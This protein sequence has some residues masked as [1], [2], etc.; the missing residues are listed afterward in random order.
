MAGRDFADELEE[1]GPE[2][3]RAAGEAAEPIAA[4]AED[5]AEPTPKR[6]RKSRTKRDLLLTALGP[7]LELWHDDEDRPYASVV[8]DGHREHWAMDSDR[9][10]LAVTSTYYKAHSSTLSAQALNDALRFLRAEAVCNGPQH[11]VYQ[12]VGA[13]GGKLYHDLGNDSWQ[14]MEIDGDG[15]RLVDNP[16]V[17]FVRTR[18][19]LALPAAERDDRGLDELRAFVNVPDDDAF[20]LIVAWLIAALRPEGPYPILLVDGEQE[21]GKSTATLFLRRLIDPK[22]SM[23]RG[24]PK[25]LTDLY[26]A[27][28]NS[29]VLSFDNL[30]GLDNATSDAICRLS[31]GGGFATRQ[32]Y[33]TFGEATF[34]GMR[35]VIANGIPNLATRPDLASRA[36]TITLQAIPDEQRRDEDQV[37][38]DFE[39]ALPR[40]LGALYDG[41]SAGLRN[42]AKVQLDGV[43]RLAAF[44]KWITAA[45]PGLGWEDKSFITAYA[46]N[47]RDAVALS[48]ESSPVGRALLALMQ[49]RGEPWQGS[50]SECLDALESHAAE[51]DTKSKSW[52]SGVPALGTALRRLRSDFRKY[53]IELS[54]DNREGKARNRFY[55]F[56]RVETPA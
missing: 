52:P 32:L 43:P 44:V 42:L 27:A 53:G 31:T 21:S 50:P 39:A 13:A 24:A 14:A 48:V 19:M 54:L 4:P 20:K 18:G 34:D 6:K 38:A 47:R 8:I 30:S 1:N 37:R 5:A 49:H 17:R 9:F 25:D 28:A 11:P 10:P 26:V 2:A 22:K 16:P 46:G 29:R 23:L 51:R 12:R 15:W 45:E 40:L 33:T 56:S 35:P 3:V 36:L 55:V 41:A 7:D